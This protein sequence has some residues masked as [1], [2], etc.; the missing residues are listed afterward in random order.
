MFPNLLYKD[1]PMIYAIVNKVNNK[2]YVGKT[3]CGYRRCHQYL[4]DFRERQI[5]H[6]NDYL[7]NAMRKVGIDNFEM[8]PLEF[9]DLNGIDARELHWMIELDSTNRN[10]GYNLRMDSS[11]GM[12]TSS[13]T[14]DKISN[15]LKRQWAEGLRDGHSE[16]LK[17]SW[18]GNSKRKKQQSKLM[19]NIKTKYEYV[20]TDPEGV[21]TLV[22]YQGLVDRGITGALTAFSRYKKNETMC[23]GYRIIRKPKGE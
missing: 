9:C 20:V 3:K 5:G 15:N 17:K 13:E 6:I 21:T 1:K 8:F 18:E 23:K 12:I 22:N 2:V 10:K 7:Y 19:T 16:K 14:S 11:T 4:Y